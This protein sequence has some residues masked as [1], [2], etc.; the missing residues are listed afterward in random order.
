MQGGASWEPHSWKW[1]AW[2]RGQACVI[3]LL[4]PFCATLG[5][6]QLSRGF[7]VTGDARLGP[8]EDSGRRR[9]PVL[10]GG[11]DLGS[12]ACWS[13]HKR[14]SPGWERGRALLSA[15]PRGLGPGY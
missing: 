10:A 4:F 5:P 13:Q 8:R 14:H 1:S 2:I 3:P 7:A 11:T 6:L 9:R 15:C 12:L